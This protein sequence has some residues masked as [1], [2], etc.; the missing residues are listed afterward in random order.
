[1]RRALTSKTSIVYYYYLFYYFF[2]KRR[3]LNGS[4]D[5]WFSKREREKD[6]FRIH[7]R[8]HSFVVLCFE[9]QRITLLLYYRELSISPSIKC[10]LEGSQ[11][12]T[13]PKTDDC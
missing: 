9:S 8:H 4:I 11:I 10:T 3:T 12:A 5:D 6:S 7:F 2:M 1:M 13:H